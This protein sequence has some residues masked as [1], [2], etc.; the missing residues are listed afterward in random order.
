MKT[1][2][3]SAGEAIRDVKDG[4][5]IMVGGFGL[6]GNPEKLIAALRARA[7]SLM[8]VARPVPWTRRC[9]TRRHVA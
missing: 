9:A 1:L 7:R 2:Q 6:C 3:A 8:A 5:T 4:A